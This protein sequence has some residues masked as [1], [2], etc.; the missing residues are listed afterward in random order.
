MVGYFGGGCVFS[1]VV[2]YFGGAIGF[3]VCLTLFF[4]R[5]ETD[6]NNYH[7]GVEMSFQIKIKQITIFN[8][9]RSFRNINTD[10]LYLY[11]INV[12]CCVGSIQSQIEI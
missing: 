6:H 9:L 10:I 3:M 12:V 2:V 4:N 8:H 11:T 1:G 5:S 7:S